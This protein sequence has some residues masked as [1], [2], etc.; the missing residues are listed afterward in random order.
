M[1]ERL[2]DVVKA[3]QGNTGAIRVLSA[4]GAVATATAKDST[5]AT[6]RAGAAMAS[7]A[8]NLAVKALQGGFDPDRIDLDQLF[9]KS[10][11]ELLKEKGIAQDEIDRIIRGS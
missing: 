3:E 11:D 5:D 9:V 7:G 6:V 2:N 4:I 10:P 1:P 8:L